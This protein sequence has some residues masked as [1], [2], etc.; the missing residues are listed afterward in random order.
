MWSL[1]KQKEIFVLWL[2]FKVILTTYITL[3]LRLQNM[4]RL[5]YICIKCVQNNK[6]FCLLKLGRNHSVHE[7]L[8]IVIF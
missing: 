6:S 2:G 4:F 3:Q 1:G 7:K 5:E 8:F